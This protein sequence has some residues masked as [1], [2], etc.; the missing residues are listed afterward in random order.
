VRETVEY[1]QELATRRRR[2][3]PRQADGDDF[4]LGA[5]SC[6]APV[7]SGQGW[8]TGTLDPLASGLLPLCFGEA[9]KFAVD[10]LAA[11][12]TY[13]ADLLFGVTTDTGDADG[14]VVE[15][16]PVAFGRGELEPLWPACAGRFARSHR[17]TRP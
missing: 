14:S 3:A 13:E 16:R 4:Q 15:R 1:P 12:K 10:L 9:T 8:H 17:C 2:L 6:P 7:F 11:D 5:A